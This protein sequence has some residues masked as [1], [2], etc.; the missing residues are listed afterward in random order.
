MVEVD[1]QSVSV[2]LSG[3]WGCEVLT[4]PGQGECPLLVTAFLEGTLRG[5]SVEKHTE[6]HG[7]VEL[8]QWRSLRPN[9]CPA[10]SPF[11]GLP[12]LVVIWPLLEYPQ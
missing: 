5:V 9:S 4:H 2:T 6:A 8:R 10:W 12:E 11:H 3:S 7:I 1:V